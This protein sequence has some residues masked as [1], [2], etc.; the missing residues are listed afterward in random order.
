MVTL[1]DR[2]DMTIAVYRGRKTKKQQQQSI[3]NA[4]AVIF[5]PF[6]QNIFMSLDVVILKATHYPT[7]FL[8]IFDETVYLIMLTLKAPN[9]NCSRRHLIFLLLSFDE[10]KACFSCLAEDSLETSSLI[11]FEKQ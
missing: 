2:P 6:K 9:K 4:S 1:T 8:N 7:D 10:N 5:S 11:F 3:S